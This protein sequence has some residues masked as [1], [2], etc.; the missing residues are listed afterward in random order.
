MIKIVKLISINIL[1]FFLIV[2]VIELISYSVLKF[3]KKNPTS[4]LIK[5]N[6]EAKK[7][8]DDPCQK[9]M[10]HP[11][12]N[13][14]H[15][16]NNMC[17]IKGGKASGEFVFYFDDSV[18]TS[19]SKF[20]VTLGGSTTDGFYNHISS[21]E[22]WPFHLSNITKKND[23]NLKI[24]N[25]GTGGYSSTQ[26]LLKLVLKVRNLDLNIKY[27]ISL[28]GINDIE[29]YRTNA[30]ILDHFPYF[31]TDILEMFNQDR[32]KIYNK[33]NI[34][35]LPNSMLLVYFINKKFFKSDYL[36]NIYDLNFI[37]L[38]EEKKKATISKY[39]RKNIS[40]ADLWVSNVKFMNSF[41]KLN[42]WKYYVFLQ[43]TMGLKGVQSQAPEKTN[44]RILL[45][46][47]EKSEIYLNKINR[48]YDKL[49]VHCKELDF[50]FDISDIAPPIGNHYNDKRHHNSKGNM[51]IA[52]E[53]FKILKN[54]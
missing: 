37:D 51:V 7:H 6:L 22:T 30:L 8:L 46:K 9:M 10:T 20:L 34:D 52:K 45:D 31:T 42:G 44:D 4:F 13:H 39:D 33:V 38:N 40:N 5:T 50:C 19:T 14:I 41:S 2:I 17:N 29:G 53:I 15:D 48:L 25:G 16:H 18:D 26:E 11:F 36:N 28:N 49:K 1:I 3:Y 27:V 43:P 47:A 32:W 21:G 35:I 54:E 24:I 23:K 12:L